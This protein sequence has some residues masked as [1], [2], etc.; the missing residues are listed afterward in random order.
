MMFNREVRSMTNKSLLQLIFSMF[1]LTF[2]LAWAVEAPKPVIPLFDELL[3][4]DVSGIDITTDAGIEAPGGNDRFTVRTDP[5]D[6]TR[7]ISR[8]RFKLVAR[9]SADNSL[10]ETFIPTLDTRS[11]PDPN[12]AAG[13]TYF[14]DDDG[15]FRVADPTS[16]DFPCDHDVNI[17]V[18]NSGATRYL[19]TALALYVAYA[20]A[21]DGL[22]NLSRATVYVWNPVN[23]NQLWRRNFNVTSGPWELVPA[24][25]AVGD[26]LDG[27]GVDE[28]RIAYQ[29]DLSNNRIQMR[30]T[31][32]AIANGNEIKEDKFIVPRA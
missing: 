25:S 24:L 27:D 19:V 7:V 28:V 11:Y 15:F 29:R 30:Y 20:N 22:V 3:M 8:L 13:T 14:C 16:E 21:A 18:A 31:Y 17:G 1:L 9:S 12:T 10:L 6:A 5:A 4:T 26:F 2:G 23:G 32:Y